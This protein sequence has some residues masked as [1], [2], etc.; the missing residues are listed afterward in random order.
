VNSKGA[1]GAQASFPLFFESNP[2]Q[3]KLSCDSL[4]ASVVTPCVTVLLIFP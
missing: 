3:A 4:S 2:E 1:R